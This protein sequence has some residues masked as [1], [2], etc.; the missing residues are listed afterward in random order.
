MFTSP[1]KIVF[2]KCGHS[3]HADCYEKLLGMEYKCPICQKSLVNMETQWRSLDASIAEQ[4]MPEEYQNR[5]AI[6]LCHDC[7]AKSAV[8]HHFLGHKCDVCKSYNTAINREFT[9]QDVTDDPSILQGLNTVL[10][11]PQAAPSQPT[12]EPLNLFHELPTDEDAAAADTTSPALH[13][14]PSSGP[15]QGSVA[16]SHPSDAAGLM[17]SVMGQDGD[18]V[19]DDPSDEE[20]EIDFWG[21]ESPR[22]TMSAESANSPGTRAESEDDSDD[23]DEEVD[24]DEDEDEDEEEEEE[25]IALF[26]HR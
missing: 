17:D 6:I 3:I 8:R 21:R 14:G 24:D 19:E 7:S 11:T 20:D 2:M 1:K 10:P 16:A 5:F 9:T 26:G 13:G 18:E 23:C 25:E 12:E 22:H 4:P 15:A